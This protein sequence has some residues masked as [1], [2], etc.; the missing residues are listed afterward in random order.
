MDKKREL[1]ELNGM[2][3]DKFELENEFTAKAILNAMEDFADFKLRSLFN[4][5]SEKDIETKEILIKNKNE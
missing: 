5:A 1:L 3:F 2:N 4:F